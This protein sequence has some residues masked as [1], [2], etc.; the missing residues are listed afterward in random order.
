MAMTIQQVIDTIIA[1]IPGAPLKNTVDVVKTGDASQPVT[2]IVTTFLAT[3]EVIRRT[4]DCGANLIITHEPTFYTHRDE[5]DWLAGDEVYEAK[6]RL[7]DQHGIVVWR[8]HDYW[9]RHRPDGIMVGMLQQLGWEAYVDPKNAFLCVIPPTRLADLVALFKERLGVASARVIG[10]PAM[11]CR[12]VGLAVG[13]SGGQS[14]IRLLHQGNLDVLACGELHE[15]ETAEY[16]RDAVD[17]GLEKALVVLGHAPSEQAGM[18]YLVEWLTPMVPGV[19]VVHI[20]CTY[21]LRTE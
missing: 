18:A 20:A 19:R 12:R 3:Y 13:A 14:H 17:M 11:V 15:W 21:P 5:V 10:D 2:A 7:L 4:V 6:R 16:V 1:A 9:H 8:F